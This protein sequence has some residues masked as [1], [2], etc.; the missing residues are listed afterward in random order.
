MTFFRDLVFP[1]RILTSFVTL[2]VRLIVFHLSPTPYFENFENLFSVSLTILVSRNYIL[3]NSPYENCLKK[4]FFNALLIFYDTKVYFFSAKT[5]LTIWYTSMCVCIYIS[6]LLIIFI[7][8]MECVNG[9]YAVDMFVPRECVR[10]SLIFDLKFMAVVLSDFMRQ[11]RVKQL[12]S[13]TQRVRVIDE[14]LL[15]I[16]R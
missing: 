2:S 3:S 12:F 8:P 9:N 7:V 16:S 11:I 4:I 10:Q 15:K 5:V 14:P 13:I 6:Q 1:T